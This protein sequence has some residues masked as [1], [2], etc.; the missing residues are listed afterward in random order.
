M[1]LLHYRREIPI[2]SYSSFLS[3]ALWWPRNTLQ[4]I[5]VASWSFDLS[6][7]MTFY[8]VAL[9][10]RKYSNKIDQISGEGCIVLPSRTAYFSANTLAK[11]YSLSR[12]FRPFTSLAPPSL[13]PVQSSLFPSLSCQLTVLPRGRSYTWGLTSSF[14]SSS[15]YLTEGSKEEKC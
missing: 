11:S 14:S 1:V 3:S 12:S 2:S 15:A 6:N 7:E 8:P 10:N 4:N 9:K 5:T 13:F